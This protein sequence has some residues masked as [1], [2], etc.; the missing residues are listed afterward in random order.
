MKNIILLYKMTHNYSIKAITK[1]LELILRDSNE[2]ILSID[3]Y[4][5]NIYNWNITVAGP[6]DSPYEGEILLLLINFST[7][8]PFKPPKINFLTKIFHPNIA[9][10][11]GEICVDILK[12]KW[13]PGNTINS[14]ILSI[15]S[16]LND[17]NPNSPL[18]NEAAI[19]FNNN[20][21]DYYQK[22][23]NYL[24]K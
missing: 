6:N 10:T 4:E 16:L 19:L 15:I 14:V 1:Q 18:N 24:N 3:P 23:R 20:K 13:S 2:H 17:P 12:E 22:I 8:Y 9:I 11:D 21:K 5:N 7:E